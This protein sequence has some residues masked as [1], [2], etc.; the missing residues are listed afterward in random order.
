MRVILAD[1]HVQP[2]GA[3]ITLLAEQPDIALV[4]EALDAHDLLRMAHK[5]IEDLVLL[6]IELP[7]LTIEETIGQ[8][9]EIDPPPIV[10]A[11]SSRSEDCTRLINA[12]ADAFVSKV[13]PSDWL[14]D[15][16]NKYVRQ[17]KAKEGKDKENKS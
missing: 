11:M 15:T 6:D 7:G 10:V 4:G 1:H 9:R 12:G 14:L 16:L 8:L 13:E 3:L 2:R 5:R 17:I